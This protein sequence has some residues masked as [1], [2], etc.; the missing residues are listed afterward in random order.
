MREKRFEAGLDLV[1]HALGREVGVDEVTE[2]QH[3]RIAPVAAVAALKSCCAIADAFCENGFC[4]IEVLHIVDL[5]P[6]LTFQTLRA[7]GC[8]IEHRDYA[9]DLLVVF[10]FAQRFD[11]SLQEWHILVFGEFPTEL[12]DV[13]GLVVAS[14]LI[15]TEALLGNKRVDSVVL[16][17]QHAGAVHPT[18]V[19]VHEGQIRSGVVEQE[20]KNRVLKDQVGFQKERVFAAE[21]FL[22]QRERIDVVG[23]IIQGIVDEYDRS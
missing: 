4:N 20:I 21:P 1:G 12:V 22:C 7:N 11:I 23:T 19:F 2:I 13:D 18:L 3:T 15:V 8:V 5:I 9:Q 14:D 17:E 6:A 16:V 10:V